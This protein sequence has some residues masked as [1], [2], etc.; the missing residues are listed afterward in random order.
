MIMSG[1]GFRG[2][3]LP[4]T[5]FAQPGYEQVIEATE[6]TNQHGEVVTVV[7]HT[8]LLE[9][10]EERDEVRFAVELASGDII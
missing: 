9:R 3:Y 7:N 5:R 1:C 4:G 2:R 8:L 10:R 6:V